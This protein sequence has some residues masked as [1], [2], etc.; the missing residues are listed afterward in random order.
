MKNIMKF[1]KNP[2]EP[3]NKL[4]NQRGPADLREWLSLVERDGGL[5]TID[6]PVSANEELAATTYM[7]AQ[8]EASPALLFTN[9][10]ND[11][12]S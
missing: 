9:I 7:A 12:S 1:A 2:E 4:N 10:E 6:A 8:N 5:L 3:G 11:K